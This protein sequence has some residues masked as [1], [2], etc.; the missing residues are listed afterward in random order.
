MKEFLINSKTHGIKTI[1]VD[2]EDYDFL[3]KFT[4]CIIKCH[5]TFYAKTTI[6]YKKIRM[7]GMILKHHN[8][9]IPLGQMIDHIDSNGLNNQKINLRV[10]S[11]SE[12]QFNV[13]KRKNSTASKYKGVRYN[14]D[15]KKWYSCCTINRK[16]YFFGYTK[17]EM[18][19]VLNYNREIKKYQG[20]YGKI[21]II[22][23]INN[24]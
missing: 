2:D 16:Y 9:D 1:L 4:W 20:D 17:T 14:K 3:S 7:H 19:S 13:G 22:E 18:E 5:N 24:K 6:N 23:T 10:V 15:K 8:I 21:N 11:N 12:N